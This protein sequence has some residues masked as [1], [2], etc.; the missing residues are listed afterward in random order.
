MQTVWNELQIYT[1]KYQTSI[2]APITLCTLACSYKNAWQTQV[3]DM[4]TTTKIKQVQ[5]CSQVKQ[6][7]NIFLEW[8][9]SAKNKLSG[10]GVKKL[11][12]W[13]SKKIIN[14]YF[15]ASFYPQRASSE[16]SA[17]LQKGNVGWVASVVKRMQSRP[18][19]VFHCVTC[20]K[21]L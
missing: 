12:G 2:Q 7:T 9:N 5:I 11:W 21:G 10:W 3:A 14:K 8:S 6:T 17:N 16:C 20:Y 4:I 18:V 1:S 19:W 13:R 15:L